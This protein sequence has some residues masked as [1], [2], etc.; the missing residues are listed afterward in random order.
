MRVV[1]ISDTHTMHNRLV[2]PSGDLLIH[3]GDFTWNG[4]GNEVQDF[5]EW[6]VAQPYQHKVF[7]AGNHER[8]YEKYPTMAREWMATFLSENVHYLQDS[9]VTIEGVK[10]Y[11]SPWQPWFYDWAFNLRTDS[12]LKEKWDL[13]PDDTDIL[14][15]HG[16]M[17]RVGDLVERGEHVGCRELQSAC[18]RIKPKL[19]VCG[20]IHE[21]YGSY[22]VDWGKVINAS[23]VDESYCAV[24][25]PIVF[26]Y[27]LTAA[28]EHAA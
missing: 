5:L 1:C 17:F 23:S 11:G 16:P 22:D 24:R 14:V 20:H 2:M 7:I 4:R 25:L 27:L 28:R 12:Q 6:F 8:S 21:G 26:D 15:T 13:I 9:S 3:A 19:H 18:R 10:I